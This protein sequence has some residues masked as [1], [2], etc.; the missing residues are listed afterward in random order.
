MVAEDR[1]SRDRS[2]S[3]WSASRFE[4]LSLHTGNTLLCFPELTQLVAVGHLIHVWL[5]QAFERHSK[6]VFD[7]FV[8]GS[9]FWIRL[10]HVP[11]AILGKGFVLILYKDPLSARSTTVAS[12]GVSRP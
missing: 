8:D 2:R 11:L 9:L 6:V 10:L 5:Q 12:S 1:S 7:P 4:S 3:L